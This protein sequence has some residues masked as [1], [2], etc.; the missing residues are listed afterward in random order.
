MS[1]TKQIKYNLFKTH[2][3][4]L[5]YQFG[6]DPS[7][8][9]SRIIG[10][11][12]NYQELWV[13]LCAGYCEYTLDFAR[14][15]PNILCLAIDIKE[16]RMMFACR[17]AE[18]EDLDNVLFLRCDILHIDQ[19]LTNLCDQ[20][21]LIHPDPQINKQRQRLNQPRY[22]QVYTNICKLGGQLTL[23][24]DN[25]DFYDEFITFNTIGPWMVCANNT[26]ILPTRYNLK[27]VDSDNLSKVFKMTK[28]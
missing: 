23:I 15:H 24:T 4:C 28:H 5:S 1:R 9:Q 13:E 7:V 22:Q 25:Q 11:L 26:K 19:L 10:A 8:V 18:Q 17:Q 14:N 21:Y 6:T 27:F 12:S 3:K 20:I 16:D 2:S